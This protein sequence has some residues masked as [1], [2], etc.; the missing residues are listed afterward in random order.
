M[1]RSHTGR[2]RTWHES[3]AS[4]CVVYF[5]AYRNCMRMENRLGPYDWLEW[6][7]VILLQPGKRSPESTD[8]ALSPADTTVPIV[9]SGWAVPHPR[10]SARLQTLGQ[11]LSASYSWI[12]G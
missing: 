1:G 4:V 8:T 2:H 12:A 5:E 11:S 9:T 7:N 10:L 6:V 3:L